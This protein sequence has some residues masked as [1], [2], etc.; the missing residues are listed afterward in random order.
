MHYVLQV[1]V[2]LVRTVEVHADT[3]DEATQCGRDAA[4]YAAWDGVGHGSFYAMVT[5]TDVGK[6]AVA[7]WDDGCGPP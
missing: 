6:T 4:R 2:E 3:L 5:R 1:K 7:S